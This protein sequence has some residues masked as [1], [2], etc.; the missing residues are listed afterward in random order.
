MRRIGV[1]LAPR[2]MDKVRTARSRR[3]FPYLNYKNI[4]ALT[5]V[6]CR[7]SG[8]VKICPCFAAPPKH[9]FFLLDSSSLSVALEPWFQSDRC[10]SSIIPLRG[11]QTSIVSP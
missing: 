9:G 7:V 4:A 2:K 1:S 11:L 6:D 5:F 3:R 8:A 10:S